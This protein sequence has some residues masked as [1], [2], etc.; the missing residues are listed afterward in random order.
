MGQDQGATARPSALQPGSF[1]T[2]RCATAGEAQHGGV[3][4]SKS[5]QE[6]TLDWKPGGPRPGS[7]STARCATA[8]RSSRMSSSPSFPDAD[9]HARGATPTGRRASIRFLCGPCAQKRP[10]IGA[11]SRRQGRG[12]RRKRH[13]P[14]RRDGRELVVKI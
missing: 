6:L 2:A 14:S 4:Y 9:L 11:F 12:L 8:T 1:S 10:H 13:K 5:P 3:R 7:Y